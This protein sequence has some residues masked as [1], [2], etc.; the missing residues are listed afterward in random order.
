M[1]VE[2]YME[3]L[4]YYELKTIFS[5]TSEFSIEIKIEGDDEK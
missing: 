2:F 3:F 4:C 5:Y 1:F